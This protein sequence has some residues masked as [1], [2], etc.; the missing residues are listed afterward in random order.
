MRSWLRSILAG[1][2]CV[3]GLITGCNPS[4]NP[5]ATPATPLDVVLNVPG[6]H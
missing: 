5:P 2:A 1:C 3:A 6:M 4:S